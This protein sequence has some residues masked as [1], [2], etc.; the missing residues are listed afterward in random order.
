MDVEKASRHP[1]TQDSLGR[2][3]SDPHDTVVNL[4]QAWAL[5]ALTLEL[6]RQGFKTWLCQS[7]PTCSWVNDPTPLHPRFLLCDTKMLFGS[8]FIG[9]W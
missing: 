5:R 2:R 7:L 4:S 8:C 3:I 6:K 1:G 9:L